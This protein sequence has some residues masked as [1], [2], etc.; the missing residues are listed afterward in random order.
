MSPNYSGG[1]GLKVSGVLSAALEYAGLA[2]AAVGVRALFQRRDTG[3]QVVDVLVESA[4]G[5]KAPVVA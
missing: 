2:S 4:R 5:E 1:S 3:S